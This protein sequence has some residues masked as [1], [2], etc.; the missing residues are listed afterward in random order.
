MPATPPPARRRSRH[1]RPLL[2]F[3]GLLVGAAAQAQAPQCKV[4][5]EEHGLWMLPGCTLDAGTPRIEE[6][7]L[8]QLDYD[9][10]GLAVVWA[11]DSFHYVTRQGRTQAVITW[12]NGPDPLAEGLLRGRVGARIGY[13]DA[14]LAQA[15]PAT[16]DFGWP[17]TDG[18]AQVCNGCRRGPAD[19][20]GHIPMEGGE[21]FHIDRQGRRVPDPA[22]P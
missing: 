22:T 12:D 13:F 16:F 10:D 5:T 6:E 1:A 4:L 17:F 11:A 2:L 20:Q 21:W 19:A 7:T 8:A 14:R 15:F 18:I 3:A 9:A